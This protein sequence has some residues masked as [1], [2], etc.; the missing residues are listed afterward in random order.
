M[1]KRKCNVIYDFIARELRTYKSSRD[2]IAKGLVFV[3]GMSEEK[4]FKLYD[5]NIEIMRSK[6]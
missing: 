6:D 3:F 1:K 4:A 5:A 2:S